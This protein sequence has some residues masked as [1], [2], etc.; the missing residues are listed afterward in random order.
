MKG[1][2]VKE[3]MPQYLAASAMAAAINYPLW[4]VSAIGQSGFRVAQSSLPISSSLHPALLP[5]AYAFAPPYKGMFA[6]VAGMTWAR[7]AI[8]WG[9]ELGKETLRDSWCGD[10][11]AVYTLFPPFV[12]STIVQCVNQPIVRASITLQ[13][14]QRHD[15]ANTRAALR[16]I[17]RDNGTRGLWHGTSAGV[18]K[19]V[20]KYCTAIMVKDFM[21]YMLP[22]PEAGVDSYYDNIMLCRAAVKSGA[23]GLA[24]AALT[25]PLDVIRNEMFKTNKGLTESVRILQEEY[26][27]ARWM[28]RGMGKNLIAVSIP[29]ACT[30]FFTDI[31]VQFTSNQN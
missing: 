4:R 27:G 29:V 2:G 6:V 28:A 23:A 3:H 5:Y 10:H 30:I 24:G 15:L 21:E 14:P 12:V 13:D 26:G 18:L 31:L 19:T 7:A 20:P 16:H 11:P 9:S 1:S 8:F 17:Y 25:N 22:K